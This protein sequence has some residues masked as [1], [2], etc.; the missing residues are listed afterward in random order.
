M[1]LV[2][3]VATDEKGDYLDSTARRPVKQRL[4]ICEAKGY[5]QLREEVRDAT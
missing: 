2:P 1:Q 5:D 3:Q 4:L